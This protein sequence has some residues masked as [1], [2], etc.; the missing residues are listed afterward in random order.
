MKKQ[1]RFSTK[2]FFYLT[3]LLLSLS[4]SNKSS[5]YEITFF[6]VLTNQEFNQKDSLI[7]LE[8]NLNN[9]PLSGIRIPSGNQIKGDKIAFSFKINAREK[10]KQKLYYKIYYQNETY[11]FHETSNYSEENF[12]GSWEDSSI[13]FK[14]VPFFDKEITV[15]D[16]F[17]IVGNPRNESLY[18]GKDPMNAIIHP[19]TLNNTINYIKSNEEWF[20]EVKKKAI[21]QNRTIENQ[22]RLD[23]IWVLEEIKNKKG[24]VNNRM[25]R[26]PR[27][28]NYE[29]M[30]VVISE[31]QYKKTPEYLKKLN[32][33]NNEGKMVNPFWYFKYGDGLNQS[34]LQIA[35]SQRKLKV[36]SLFSLRSGIFIDKTHTGGTDKTKEYYS[37]TCGDSDDLLLRSHFRQYFHYINKDYPLKNIPIVLDVLND[38]F[39]H[40]QYEQLKKTYDANNKFIYTYVNS[41]NC[42]CKTVAVDTAENSISIINP[43]IKDNIYMKE[44]V[45]V[46]GRIGLSYGKWRAKIKFPK[47]INK[48]NVWTGI[49]NAFWLLAEQTGA[50]YNQRR[51]CNADI[52]YIPKNEPNNNSALKKSR[53]VDGYSEID[54]EILKESQ[55]WP[56]TSYPGKMVAPTDNA[57]SNNEVM[58]TCTNWDL[59]CHE[60]A[61][62]DIGARKYIID[63]KEYVF[64]RWDHFYKAL[65]TKVP[66]NHSEMFDRDYYYFEIGWYPTKIIWRIGREKNSMHTVC[67]MDNTVTSIPNNQM[68]AVVTQEWHSQEWWP[69]APYKQNYI[70][71]PKNDIIGKILEIEVE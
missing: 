1:Y 32:L 22:V 35:M 34:N 2:I 14:E 56:K 67:I 12:Y 50:P 15:A 16:S 5:F 51:P 8:A 52:A 43:G 33:K 45:G 70:P 30:L 55:Y 38:T 54:F 44:Q 69:T 17:S 28:G 13:T 6:E 20:N 61:N 66:V 47:L 53:K 68:V 63:G 49:T 31:E 7:L 23:A 19:D 58:I 59:A 48:N 39:S 9:A 62:F 26:N 3:L 36:K 46:A 21:K 4:C 37:S 24:L 27:M 18:F 11:K 64:H 25:W 10:T 71:F 41:S 65:T 40:A 57:A 60:P 42:P 29:F